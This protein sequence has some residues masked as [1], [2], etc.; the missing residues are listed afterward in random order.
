M[1]SGHSFRKRTNPLVSIP[2]PRPL[3][4]SVAPSARSEESN[5][6]NCPQIREKHLDLVFSLNS[7]PEG[8]RMCRLSSKT[9]PSALNF[10]LVPPLS[11]ASASLTLQSSVPSVQH[12][13][14]QTD[15]QTLR[16]TVARSLVSLCSF[17]LCVKISDVSC[18][19]TPQLLLLHPDI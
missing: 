8:S 2:S 5:R 10:P 1:S 11:A 19:P 13:F 15:K 7:P 14:V 12:Q 6:K 17:R 3:S 4:G 16:Q 18:R 9:F